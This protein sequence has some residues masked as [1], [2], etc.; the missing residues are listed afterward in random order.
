MVDLGIEIASMPLGVVRPLFC[1]LP[2][3]SGSEELPASVQAPLNGKRVSSVV[4]GGTGNT[5]V[6]LPGEGSD[7]QL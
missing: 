2:L 6:L 5:G 1:Q 4:C 7:G 3:E